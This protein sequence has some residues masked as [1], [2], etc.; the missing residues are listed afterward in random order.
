MVDHLR[1]CAAKKSR[2]SFNRGSSNLFSS[3]VKSIAGFPW[4]W[5]F[6]C[7]AD[8]CWA[9]IRTHKAL[10]H[11][12]LQPAGPLLLWIFS[13]LLLSPLAL[14]SWPVG[15]W[16][17]IVSVIQ[18]NSIFCFLEIIHT[19]PHHFSLL[20]LIYPRIHL[21]DVDGVMVVYWCAMSQN[22]F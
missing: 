21:P 12:K 15:T 18:L 6:L 8:I 3:A 2:R 20:H 9:K 5:I 4:H 7:P 14:F 16:Y 10:T 13:L 17:S 1:K 22:I 19:G 11:L